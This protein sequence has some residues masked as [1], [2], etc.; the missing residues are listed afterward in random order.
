MVAREVFKLSGAR[1]VAVWGP[2]E[3]KARNGDKVVV[4]VDDRR[5]PGMSTIELHGPPEGYPD[6]WFALVISGPAADVVAE[7][8]EIESAQDH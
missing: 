3:G 7:G 6:S 5:V 8:S 4:I 2:L 1:G